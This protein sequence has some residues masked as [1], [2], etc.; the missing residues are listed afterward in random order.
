MEL[1]DQRGA[2]VAYYDPHVQ[3]IAKSGTQQMGG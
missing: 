3:V 2:Q 1:L